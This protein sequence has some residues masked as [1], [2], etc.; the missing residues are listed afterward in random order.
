M[1]RDPRLF[2]F[3]IMAL[4]TLNAARWTYEGKFAD[5]AYWCGALWLTIV[6]T[7]FYKH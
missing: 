3:V 6:V 1:L 7:F 2:N 5:A 4:Y